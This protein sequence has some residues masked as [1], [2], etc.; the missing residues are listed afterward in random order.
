MFEMVPFKRNGLSRKGDE[1]FNNFLGSFFNDEF[2]TPA[3]FMGSSFK[4]DLKETV[5]AYIVEADLPGISK[6]AI[7]I[8]YEKNY[9]TISAKREDSVEDKKDNYVRRERHYGEF[10]RSFYVDNID[11]AKIQ[12]SFKDGVLKV[13]LPKLD[14]E[15][16]RRKR[17]DIQ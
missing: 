12:A 13:N 17:I 14:K 15:V 6:E 10:R 9:L 11:E 16:Q 2:L 8:D 4:V 5:E 1:F 7:N 3:A